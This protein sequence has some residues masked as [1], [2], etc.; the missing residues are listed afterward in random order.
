MVEER[1]EKGGSVL[2]K[3]KE[4]KLGL[5]LDF[6][7]RVKEPKEIKLKVIRTGWMM[8]RLYGNNDDEKVYLK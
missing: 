4:D 7:I 8:K 3:D 5:L 1:M 6:E 2:K